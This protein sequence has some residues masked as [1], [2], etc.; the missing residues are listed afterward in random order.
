MLVH[1]RQRSVT[2]YFIILWGGVNQY[3]IFF[4]YHK[5]F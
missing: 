5:L 3:Q 4:S 1:E 2:L